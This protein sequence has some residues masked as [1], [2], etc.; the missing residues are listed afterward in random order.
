MPELP[1][2]TVVA[3]G[4]DQ[5]IGGQRVGQV[6][7]LTPPSW[8]ID[9]TSSQEFLVGSRVVRVYRRGKVV[10]VDLASQYSL[11]IH[12]KMTGQL[13]YIPDRGKSGRIGFGHPSPSLVGDLPDKTTRV[14]WQ[15]G[16]GRLFFNDGRRFGWV[17]LL[18]TPLVDESEPVVSLGPD[19]L[20]ITTAELA[21]RLAGRQRGIKACLLDQAIL[22]GC[23]NIYADESLWRSRIDP[24][25]PAGQLTTR[26]VGQIR[27]QMQRVFRLSIAQG[28]SSSRNYVN[29]EGRR[30]D[31]L[32]KFGRVYG[33]AG[34][35][36]H[37]CRRP[38]ERI[39]V[40]ARG[41]H[42]CPRCQGGRQ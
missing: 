28:G 30:G 41:T 42:W 29:A 40:A 23:G 26:Q 1:E 14:I 36:C 9:K 15:F 27:S 11:M 24:K 4:L 5:L 31:Y 10:V 21:A 7:V 35:P 2:V 6:E 18:P 13:V 8:Q 16:R 3:V 25:T 19:A 37:R 17:R 34:Q 20:T 33:R 22:A 38:I 12:L 39:V 32:S